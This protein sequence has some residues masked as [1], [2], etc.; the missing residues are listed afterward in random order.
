[1]KKYDAGRWE[2][3]ELS[4]PDETSLRLIVNDVEIV[5]IQC[6]PDSYEELGAGFLFTNR[7]ID[8]I[9][10]I[11]DIRFSSADNSLFIRVK[12]DRF[13]IPDRLIITT[14]FGGGPAFSPE[15]DG[16]CVTAGAGFRPDQIIRLMSAMK[17]Q[18]LKY[19]RSGGIHATAICTAAD[20]VYLAEDVGRQNSMDKVI[21]RC[22]LS[23]VASG[24]KALLTTGRISY[25]MVMKA[26]RA[27]ISV[28]ASLSAPTL[29][30]VEHAE[31]CG[32]SVVG[33][34]TCDGLLVYSHEHR[35]TD[36]V[37]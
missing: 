22:L 30:A 15:P 31:I 27:G 13:R 21:G 9:S 6:S 4:P 35:L 37:E 11:G 10:D 12:K 24:G 32:I 34:V 26:G 14:G 36:P 8:D 3:T 19:Q 23:G 25:E 29:K 20:I 17:R 28:L 18:A 16:G 7:I 33:Y 2:D 5:T 1:M